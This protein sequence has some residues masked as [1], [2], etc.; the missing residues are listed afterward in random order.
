MIAA[1][2]QASPAEWAILGAAL[3][4]L[5]FYIQRVVRAPSADR[6]A[7]ANA[8]DAVWPVPMALMFFALNMMLIM[9]VARSAA[10]S[11]GMARA[12][13]AADVL[14]ALALWGWGMRRITC[15]RVRPAHAILLGLLTMLA[16]LPVVYGINYIQQFIFGAQPEQEAVRLLRLG[17]DGTLELAFMA[18]A[19]AP[20]T[21]EL[22]FRGLLYNGIRRAQ[23]PRT[24][25]LVTSL[26]FGLVHAAS[27]AA[28]IPMIVLGLF[29]ATLMERTGSLLACFVAHAAFNTLT[30]VAL[31]LG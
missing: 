15:V 14:L 21:E 11:P 16:A 24:A 9:V 4:A 3:L 13:L 12:A 8:L 31:F 20:L 2:T 27:P 26:V 22:V 19:V 18:I 25:L 29:L 30:V 28:V 1:A 23:S 17:G 6:P 5:P 7:L 10:R